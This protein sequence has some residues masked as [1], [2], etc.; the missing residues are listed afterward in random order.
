MIQ[1]RRACLSAF[2]FFD[3]CQKLLYFQTKGQVRPL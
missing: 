2:C 1:K 3:I